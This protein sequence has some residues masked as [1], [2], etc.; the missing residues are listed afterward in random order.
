MG[1]SSTQE[2]MA[3]REDP[4]VAVTDVLK[5]LDTNEKEKGDNK[6]KEVRKEK[7][8]VEGNKEKEEFCD[9]KEGDENGENEEGKEN[10]NTCN[11]CNKENP[12][13]RC[14]KRHPKCIKKLFCN[15]TCEELAHKK[16]AAAGASKKPEVKKKKKQYTYKEPCQ[17]AL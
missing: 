10:M 15:T 5:K 7:T 12:S 17:W 2:A 8:N 13:K 9:I 3:S 11:F 4:I 6:I 16:K 1:L 14:S